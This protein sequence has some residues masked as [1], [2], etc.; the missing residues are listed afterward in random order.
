MSE[1]I[2]I[3]RRTNYDKH[4]VDRD[5]KRF[6]GFDKLLEAL[7][8]AS[9]E[10]E[11]RLIIF[12]FE[13]GG[14]VVENLDISTEMFILHEDT[15][16]R[17]IEVRDMMLEK[18]YRKI[19]EYRENA[20][21]VTLGVQEAQLCVLNVDATFST[22]KR[23][24]ETQPNRDV[25]RNDFTIAVDEPLAEMLWNILV[26]LKAK[27]VKQ[28]FLN[29][30][31]GKPYSAKWAWE[32]LVAIGKQFG[33]DEHGEPKFYLYN[34][35]LRAERASYLGRKLKDMTLTEWFSW[36]SVDTAMIY[37]KRGVEGQA[38][39]LGVKTKFQA[40]DDGSISKLKLPPRATSKV[41]LKSREQLLSNYECSRHIQD[42][43][44]RY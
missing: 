30:M 41:K 39:E 29:P 1:F 18:R 34:H 38:E 33:V 8:Y 2:K 23:R 27:G 35:R 24:F 12:E 5:V 40:R 32:T 16:P 15:E 31:K 22:A 28:I 21:N 37:C 26:E 3:V 10:T 6:C 43:N 11:R 20:S 17:T 42:N 9:N 36:E 7:S 19:G 13:L 25:K 44:I 14:R 4:S